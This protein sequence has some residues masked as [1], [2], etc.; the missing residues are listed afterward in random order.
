MGGFKWKLIPDTFNIIDAAFLPILQ[1]YL[2]HFYIFCNY[3]CVLHPNISFELCVVNY[4][5]DYFC[6]IIRL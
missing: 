5:T 6:Y 4:P 2:D 3:G 1:L